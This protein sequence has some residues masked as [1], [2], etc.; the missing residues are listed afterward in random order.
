MIFKKINDWYTVKSINVDLKVTPN[1]DQ[2]SDFIWKSNNNNA[3]PL[4]NAEVIGVVLQISRLIL[5]RKLGFWKGRW[6]DQD[7]TSG[8]Q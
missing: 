5:I 7:Y 4:E 6:I 2:S 1:E 8:K 3:W